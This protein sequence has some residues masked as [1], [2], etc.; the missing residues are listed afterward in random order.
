MPDSKQVQF[1]GAQDG[2]A[3]TPSNPVQPTANPV[4]A[5]APEAT[6]PKYV[7]MDTFEKRVKEIEDAAF[8]RAQSYVDKKKSVIDQRFQE[9][10][11]LLKTVG[12]ELQPAQVDALRNQ[13]AQKVETSPEP[14]AQPSAAQQN[15]PPN[16]APA[17]PLS[18]LAYN[19]MQENGILIEDADPEAKFFQT[20][21][22]SMTEAISITS[23]AIEAKRARI[24]TASTPLGGGGPADPNPIRDINDPNELFQRA[25]KNGRW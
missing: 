16:D 3:G 8:R 9:Q 1:S 7:D 25:F 22:K 20:R 13:I 5:G 12:V 14:L 23:K 21:P 11:D 4:Q 24:A 19:L 18:L 6:T 15:T 10:A 2:G 17:D